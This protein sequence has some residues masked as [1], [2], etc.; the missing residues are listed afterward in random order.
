[1]KC[2]HT[3]TQRAKSI[4]KWW[5]RSHAVPARAR[6]R[7][8]HSS[9]VGTP[10]LRPS[11]TDAQTFYVPPEDSKGAVDPDKLD[12]AVSMLRLSGRHSL[13]E[14]G[15]LPT[16]DCWLLTHYVAA[17][18]SGYRNSLTGGGEEEGQTK[19][20]STASVGLILEGKE[21]AQNL[22]TEILKAILL[23]ITLLNSKS[24]HP[25]TNIF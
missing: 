18:C 6:V 17:G 13:A 23:K 7:T 5:L 15:G 4:K 16:W 12:N 21:C 1:M 8:Y 3:H 9:S 11:V 20:V 24:I 2:T 10:R 19:I 22:E 14:D 25:K